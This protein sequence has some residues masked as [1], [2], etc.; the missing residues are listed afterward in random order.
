M[1]YLNVNEVQERLR[2]LTRVPIDDA[3]IS[4]EFTPL[5]CNHFTIHF[6]AGTFAY[7]EPHLA[8]DN[9][10]YYDSIQILIREDIKDGYI[11]ICPQVDERFKSFSWAKYF[12]YINR[13]GKPTPS[14]MGTY[15]P[16]PEVLQ[17]I[18]EVYKVSRLRLF[19]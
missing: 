19:F 1:N 14:Y 8:L 6:S 18:R 4:G 17:L 7:S 15:L 11:D 12:T 10:L 16:Q 5:A 2:S 3:I 9:L 13:H